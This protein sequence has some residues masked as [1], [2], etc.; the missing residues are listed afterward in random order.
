MGR[1]EKIIANGNISDFDSFLEENRKNINEQFNK[2]MLWCI[3]AGPFIAVA[4]RFNIFPGVT[5]YTAIFTSVFMAALAFVHRLLINKHA[6]SALAGLITLAAID[7]LL[8]VMDSAHLTIYIS[9]FLIPLLALQ[10]CD[11]KV[12]TV[13]VIFNYGFMVFCTWNM[14]PYFAERRT[15]VATPLAY[16]ISRLGGLTIEM[17][18]MIAAGVSLCK[19]MSN[20]YKTLILQYKNLSEE[21]ERSLKLKD[22]TDR[23]IAASE[24]KSAF[25]SNMSHEIR[26]PINA[27]LGMNEMILR[28]SAD[29]DV[30]EYSESIKIAGN[31]LL[32]IINDILDFS[33]IESGKIEIFPV[34]YDLSSVIND[35]VNMIRIKADDKGLK[36]NLDFDPHI[37]KLLFGDEVRVKQVITNILTNAVKYTEKGSVTFSIGYE[38]TA[39]DPEQIILNVSVKDT[40]IGIKEEDMGKLFSEF[41]RIEEE[42][43]RNI[44]G[45]GLGMSITKKLLEMMGTSLNVESTYGVGSRFWFS[46]R[47]KVAGAEELGDYE[48]SFKEMLSERKESKGKF[49]APDASVLVI[50][51]NPMNLVVFK[52]LLK[53]TNMHIDTAGS[54]DEGLAFAADKKYDIIF[55]DHMMPDKDGIETLHEMQSQTNNPNTDTVKVC[56]TANAISGAREKYISE[57]F[58]DY[59]T[60]PIDAGKLEGMLLTY[61]PGEKIN[62]IDSEDVLPDGD[63]LEAEIV[64]PKNLKALN[65]QEFIDVYEGVSLSGDVDAYISLLKIFKDTLDDKINEIDNFYK[66][67]DYKNYT[68]KVHAL[69]SSARLVGAGKLADKAQKLEDAGKEDNTSYINDNHKQFIEELS[70]IKEPLSAVFDS[71]SDEDDKPYA[72]DELMN[73]VFEEINSAASDMDCDRIDAVIAEIKDYRIPDKYTELWNQILDAFARFDY[74]TIEDL[75]SKI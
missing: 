63:D 51:D 26:T 1:A 68:I 47:Q 4:V 39:D 9:W 8:Y 22:E 33:K 65:E 66:N 61:L 14:A 64:L 19:I 56:L 3:L 11:L 55:F 43:N 73:D 57:G 10:F 69:K 42:R 71:P 24:A 2:V 35:L 28:E 32:G 18:V 75:L 52:S 7:V 40:G 6:T 74:M 46:L 37:P 15:D 12:Y 16:F 62:A 21:K 48:A 45:T 70:D 17:I 23:A 29:S 67:G 34:D 20:H 60:K 25:L 30:L 31:T 58:D 72:D 44:E 36:L 59:L 13:S 27:M 53:R 50:D 5:Y 49:L 54:G 38:Y 41:E